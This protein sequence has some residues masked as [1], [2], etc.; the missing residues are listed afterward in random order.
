MCNLGHLNYSTALPSLRYTGNLNVCFCIII[1]REILDI[2]LC[3]QGSC[4]EDH[5][6]TL[7]HRSPV[8]MWYSKE[9]L[10]TNN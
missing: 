6:R 1:I 8:L 4:G 10:R 3:N 2:S 9:L 5:T 7:P